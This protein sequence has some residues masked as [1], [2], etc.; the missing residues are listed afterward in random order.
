ME[1]LTLV[2]PAKDESESL[3]RVL[4]ELKH[5]NLK[6]LVVIP[7]NDQLTKESIKNFIC[8]IIEEHNGKGYGMLLEQELTK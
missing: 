2:I 1:R 7:K 4:E 5:S 8:K 3:P 6:V